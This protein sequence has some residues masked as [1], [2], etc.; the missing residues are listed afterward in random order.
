MKQ[1]RTYLAPLT[2]PSSI[3]PA[4]PTSSPLSSSSS[5]RRTNRG[6]AWRAP[7]RPRPPPASRTPPASPGLP[8]TPRRG[9]V[10]PRSSSSPAASPLS[11]VPSLSPGP[12]G[13]AATDELPRGHRHPPLLPDALL[14][15]AV[16]PS[17]S[18]SA[19][20]TGE[21]PKRR[22]DVFPLLGHRGPPLSIRRLRCLPELPEATVATPVSSATVSPSFPLCLIAVAVA[23][24]MTETR[25]R[26]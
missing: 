16:P 9:L 17:T 8:R 12:N 26:L 18:P 14:S 10:S 15:S 4:Q 19:H 5:A 2:W 24:L 25:R 11:S 3:W 6:E 23:P 22:P 21:A 13:A 7:E 1:N 20:A